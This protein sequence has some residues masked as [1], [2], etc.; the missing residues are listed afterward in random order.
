MYS[1]MCTK[2]A[3]SDGVNFWKQACCCLLVIIEFWLTSG[4]L[5]H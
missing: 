5:G 3:V 4:H 2:E 1:Y